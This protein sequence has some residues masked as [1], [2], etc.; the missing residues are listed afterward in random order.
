LL[1]EIIAK[2]NLDFR[3]HLFFLIFL[4][5]IGVL[6]DANCANPTA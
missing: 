6:G 1:L 2:L 3:M 5:H 4:C